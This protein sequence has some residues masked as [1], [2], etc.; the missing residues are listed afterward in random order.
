M[1]SPVLCLV[2]PSVAVALIAKV[3][4]VVNSLQSALRQRGEFWDQARLAEIRCSCDVYIKHLLS[5][6]ACNRQRRHPQATERL[7]LDNQKIRNLLTFLQFTHGSPTL[8][9]R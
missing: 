4:K 3:T 5:K 1:K 6:T 2:K 9:C 7:L 8:D